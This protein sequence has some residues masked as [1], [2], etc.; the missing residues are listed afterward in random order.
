MA[1]HTSKGTVELRLYHLRRLAAALPVPLDVTTD[2]LIDWL[3]AHRWKASTTRSYRASFRA[4]WSWA[5]KTGRLPYSPAAEVPQVRVQ[6]GKPRPTPEPVLAFALRVADAREWLLLKLGGVCGLRR[7]EIA[8]THR[9]HLER[10]LLGW[11]L[12]VLGKGDRERL[13]PLPEDVAKVILGMP[14]DYLFPSP[15]GGHLTPG[16][17]GVLAKRALGSH[18]THTLRHRAGTNSYAATKDLRAVQELL[19]HASPE[20]TAIYTEVPSASIR[21]AMEGAQIKGDAA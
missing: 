4:F 18:S 7:G 1:G 15:H 9:R 16:H 6:P 13:V 5:V 14:D 12:R 19:G 20:T 2:D 10:D 17:I 8:R 3:G 11:C 21:A